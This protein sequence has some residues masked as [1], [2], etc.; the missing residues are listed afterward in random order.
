MNLPFPRPLLLLLA[1][2]T[3]PA[4]RDE[5]VAAD[6]EDVTHALY[7]QLDEVLERRKTIALEEG[8]GA[9]RERE[10]LDRLAEEI[11]KRIVRLDPDADVDALVHRLERPQ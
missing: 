3:A 7:A 1:G 10:E 4:E 5:R 2:C 6:R 9:Q 8:D 11:A